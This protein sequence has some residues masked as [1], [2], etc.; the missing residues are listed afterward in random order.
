[1]SHSAQHHHDHHVQDAAVLLIS[2]AARILLMLGTAVLVGEVAAGPVRSYLKAK[3]D[4]HSVNED[5]EPA[6]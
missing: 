4:H 5:G 3:R 1:M 6:D 2:S